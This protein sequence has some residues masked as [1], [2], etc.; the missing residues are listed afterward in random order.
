MKKIIVENGLAEI[1]NPYVFTDVIDP[2]YGIYQHDELAFTGYREGINRDTDEKDVLFN[3]YKAEVDSKI[4]KVGFYTTK[5][6]A[7]YEV[8]LVPEFSELE[9]KSG[10][11]DADEAEKFYEMIQEYKILAGTTEKAGYHTLDIPA[12][13]IAGITKGK[14]FA[15]GIWTRNSDAEDSEHKYDMV[16]EKKGCYGTG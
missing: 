5:K 2:Q 9:E 13:K 8:Y 14:D 4:E 6:N 12:D 3:R 15:V 1:E 16:I 7:E 10:E 11:F